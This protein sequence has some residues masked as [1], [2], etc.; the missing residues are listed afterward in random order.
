LAKLWLYGVE[1]DWSSFYKQQQC[2]RLPLPTYPFERQRYWI[3]PPA[4]SKLTQQGKFIATSKKDSDRNFQ[5]T[6]SKKP[7]IADWFYVPSW[8]RSVT[9]KLLPSLIEV[10]QSECWIF[11]IDE[12]GLGDQLLD[13]LQLQGQNAIALRR[14]SHFSR[15][16]QYSYQINPR[17]P[18]DYNTL[19]Q[20]LKSLNL[21]PKKIVHLWSV[22]PDD[23]PASGLEDVE[24]T[25]EQGL[26]S[27]LFLAQGL[28]QQNLTDELQITVISSQMQQVTGKEKLCPQKATLLG[29]VKVIPQEY[30]NI[31]CRSIDVLPPSPGSYQEE[32]FLEHLL[33]ELAAD[34]SNEIIAYRGIHR[35]LQTWEPIRLDETLKD[36]PRL[37]EKGVYL[38]TGGLGAIGLTLA[39]HLAKT[40]HAKLVLIARS[41]FPARDEW[42]QWLLTHNQEDNI[43]RK[44]QKLQDFE[45]LGSEVLV[46]SA[47]VSNLQQMTDA[48]AQTLQRFGQIDGVIHAAGVLG[49]S[50]IQR[51]TLDQ[52]ESVLAPKLRGTLVLDHLLK[53]LE[54][55]FFVLCSSGASIQP[56]FGQVAYC[57]ANNFLDAFAHYKTSTSSSLTISLNWYGW[58]EGGMGV[59]ATKRLAPTLA[60]PTPQ[61][62]PISHPLFDQ[63]LIEGEEQ[64]IYICKL[65]TKKH[66]VVNEHRLMGKGTLPGTAYL[67]M[68]L[69]AACS[70]A[71]HKTLELQE[72]TFLT[73]LTIEDDEEKEVRTVLKRQTEGWEFLITSQSKSGQWSEHARG[74]I[75]LIEA[76]PSKKHQIQE[77]A[78]NCNQEK[79]A[80]ADTAQKTEFLEFG[81]RWKNLQQL[82]FGKNHGLALLE[83]PE[84]FIEDLKSYKLHPALLDLATGSLTS[85]FQQKELY[86][87]FSYKRLQFKGSLPKKIYSYIQVAENQQP[88]TPTLTFNII[89]MDDQGTELVEIEEYTLRKVS[90]NDQV[91]GI[92]SPKS[93]ILPEIENFSVSI[94]SP[95][96]LDTITFNPRKRQAPGIGE[97]EIEVSA[98]GLNFKEVLIALGLIPLPDGFGFGI[99][100][101]GKIVA[102]GEGVEGLEVGDEVIAFSRSC[103]SQFITANAQLVACK[104]KHLTLEEAATIPI[105]FATAYEA[106]I[107]YGRLQQGEKVLIHAAAG[108]VGLAAVQI[109]Q[110]VGA[111]IFATAGSPEKREFL[112][113]LGIE[114]VMDSRSLDFK[115]EVLKITHGQGVDVVLN[116]LSGEFISK[117]ISILAPYGR[118]LELGLRD[119]LSNTQLGLKPFE[120]NL[121]FTAI[122]LNPQHPNFSFLWQEVMQHFQQG[123]FSPLPLRVFP[124]TQLTSAFEYMARAKHIGKIVVSLQEQKV[125]EKL[126]VP[127]NWGT[128]ALELPKAITSPTNRVSKDFRQDWLSPS[129]GIEVFRRILGSTLPQVLVFPRDLFAGVNQTITDETLNSL[130]NSERVNLFSPIPSTHLRPELKNSYVAPK[131]EIEQTISQIWQE[132]LGIKEVGRNDNFFELGGDSL[133][134]VQVRSKLQK[135]L[136]KEFSIADAFDYPTISALAEY[137]S[138]EKVE[139]LAFEQIDERANRLEDAIAE[140]AEIIEQRRKARE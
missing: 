129:E 78:A 58:K 103:L 80:I 70:H 66:W 82:K 92:A 55:D 74:S 9:P 138:G 34:T 114:H 109:A 12:C 100:C 7:D 3:D 125:I 136:N 27:L 79:I 126:L 2:H 117:G 118:F 111:E 33:A 77:L 16:S 21:T 86:L 115:D 75:A 13:R 93:P 83:L 41:A 62:K 122:N 113:S 18:D 91:S 61:T 5:V 28:G 135:I 46:V 140:D 25:Q 24:Q 53:D 71:G 44:I 76:Q 107:R 104:P 84:E 31:S 37:K 63:Y 89:I 30:P 47:D 39:E 35:W 68:A 22:I 105:A 98:V 124:I 17:Q 85:K 8:K 90:I 6:S 42:Q 96:L 110:W 123:N 127:E 20:E 64:E 29:A 54:L 95:A 15:L 1:I 139:E 94:S 40:V 56:L 73:P 50:A 67:E 65:S 101:T 130:K 43:S 11:F 69:A 72:V 10:A 134:I 87:P 137:L 32:I 45:Q 131:N 108:G 81:P 88:Q 48:I 4:L 59:E 26:Y 119:I 49:D 19:F 102:V 57:G 133:L 14:G 112:R 121:S 106:L 116:S 132:V 23:Y 120:Q 51:K 38:I 97:V 52:V 36:T 60:V 99:E 128:K